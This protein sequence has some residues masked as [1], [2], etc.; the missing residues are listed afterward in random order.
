MANVKFS[1]FTAATISATGFIVGYDSV[2][3]DNIR[4]TLAQ[5]ETALTLN[6][7]SGVLGTAKGGML[8]GGTAS[9]VLAKNTN[10]NYD[11]FWKTLTTADI[12]GLYSVGLTTDATAVTGTSALTIMRSQ[13]IPAGTFGVKNIAATIRQRTRKT[14]TGGTYTIG[15]YVNTTPSLTGALQLGVATTAGVGFL[16]QQ[17]KRELFFKSTTSTETMPTNSS[18]HTDDAFTNQTVATTNINWGINQ[19]ILFTTQNVSLTDSVVQTGF[20]IALL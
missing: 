19:Y 10:S 15:I 18:A 4:L 1:Q 12:S 2:L 20:T 7:L 17:M 13:L 6:N 11:L 16:G 14:G 8:T 9:Q 5:L 3:N